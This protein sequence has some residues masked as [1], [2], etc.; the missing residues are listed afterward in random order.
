MPT[1][2]VPP[3]IFLKHKGVTIYRIYKNDNFSQCPRDC[4]FGWD[5]RCSDSGDYAFDVRD[6]PNPS[7]REDDKDI[8]RDAIDAGIITSEGL[9]LP[10]KEAKKPP[11]GI[12]ELESRLAA[13]EETIQELQE[14]LDRHVRT[15][16]D[17]VHR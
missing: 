14:K 9:S 11:V 2:W 4:W 6:L 5:E 7:E 12:E 16:I 10:E 1:D 17:C 3:E 8:I 13:A 15:R